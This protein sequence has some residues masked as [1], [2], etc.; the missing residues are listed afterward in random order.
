MQRERPPHHVLDPRRAVA[1]CDGRR[2]GVRHA[3]RVRCRP[4]RRHAVTLGR[5]LHRDCPNRDLGSPLCHI[6]TRTGL[7][8][9]TSAPG[10]GSIQPHPYRDLGSPLCHIRTGTGLTPPTSAPGLRYHTFLELLP[11]LDMR[12]AA[13]AEAPL[14]DEFVR[15][16]RCGERPRAPAHALAT[17]ASAR[18]WLHQRARRRPPVRA[19]RE[20][21]RAL[22]MHRAAQCG[23]AWRSLP[24]ARRWRRWVGGRA[25]AHSAAHRASARRWRTE[26]LGG[27][28][29]WAHRF[30][31]YSC[32]CFKI[33]VAVDRLPNFACYP[34][35][36]DGQPGPQVPHAPP[37]PP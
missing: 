20:G 25:G 9:P 34:T 12:G 11:G 4:Q 28:S 30:A 2:A 29:L 27:Y 13:R 24:A 16:I 8:P 23:A 35:A 18:A 17:R 32:Q 5:H 7:A 15:H 36:A 33:N 37:R 3:P 22:R 10:L 19:N 14:P 21:A 31:D 26:G 1:A 6:R